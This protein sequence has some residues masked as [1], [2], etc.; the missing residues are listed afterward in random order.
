[1]SSRGPRCCRCRGFA[2]RYVR[3]VVF[4]LQVAR[5]TAVGTLKDGV[6]L[7]DKRA[8]ALV[9]KHVPARRHEQGLS[10]CCVVEA[11]IFGFSQHMRILGAGDSQ[12]QHSAILAAA[13][14]PGHGPWSCS[15]RGVP[16][17]ATS[18]CW[19]WA[20]KTVLVGSCGV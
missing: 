15:G 7:G 3:D 6:A 4:R 11:C 19:A 12:K 18:C 9:V 20:K 10:R 1:M 17:R 8:Q 14:S 16:N 5:R 13:L 2:Q